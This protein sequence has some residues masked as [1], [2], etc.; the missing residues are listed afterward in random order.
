MNSNKAIRKELIAEISLFVVGIAAISLLYT[1]NLLLFI[2][3]LTGWL[4]GIKFWHTKHD[5]YFFVSGAIIGPICEM[6][7]IYF[8]AWQ[9][10][11]PT[12][13][14]VPI[15]LPLA[16]G[17]IILLIKRVAE[18]FVRIEMK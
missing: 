10:A 11:N 8:G 16:W 6:V 12:A 9:Y 2:V 7:A 14:G 4:T 18:T 13:F 17:I 5:V 15:W 1:N 3:L